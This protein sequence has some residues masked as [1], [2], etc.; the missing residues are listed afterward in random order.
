MKTG[1]WLDKKDPCVLNSHAITISVTPNSK[2]K[3]LVTTAIKRLKDPEMQ[4]VL[5]IGEGSSIQQ[6]I[7]CA[8]VMKN[9]MKN[10]GQLS[11]ITYQR[12]EEMWM[13]TVE[14]LE[15]LTVTRNIP[16]ISIRLFKLEI[17]QSYG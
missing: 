9:R 8:D 10:L 5:W 1:G 4:E 16:S 12:K 14:G 2:I 11:S 7:I 15:Q 3:S 13:P 6:A 17:K